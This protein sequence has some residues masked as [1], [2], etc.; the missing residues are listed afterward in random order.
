M[1]TQSSNEMRLYNERNQ[2]LY[3]NAAELAR[4]LAAAKRAPGPQRRFALT[5]AYTGCRLS[6]ARSLRYG[7][8]QFEARVLSVRCLKKRD[9]HVVREL[10]LPHPLAAEYRKLACAH[11]ELM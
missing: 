8:I 6:E 3:L 10:P 4:F 1:S 9:R 11:D 5:L 7:A 2:R